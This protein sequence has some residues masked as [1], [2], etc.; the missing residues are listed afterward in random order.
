MT[1]SAETTLRGITWNHTRGFAPVVT[2][3]QVYCDTQEVDVTWE[4]R[5]LW[6]FGEG[7]LAELVQRYDLIVIDHPFAGTCAN[8]RLVVPLDT[9]LPADVLAE[10]AEHSVGPSFRS[11]TYADRQWALPLDAAAQVA[12][13]RE[14]L[15]AAACL[16]RPSTWDEALELAAETGKVAVPLSPVNAA[17][18]FFSLCTGFGEEPFAMP[19]CIVPRVVAEQVLEL[20]QRLV[21]VIPPQCLSMNPI[22]VLNWASS[23]DDVIYVPLTFGYV[24]YSHA[25]YRPSRL[26]FHNP[27]GRDIG[28]TLGGAGIAI[29]AQSRHPYAAAELAAW[30]TSSE[31]QRTSFALSGGQPAHAA[32]WDDPLLDVV[33]DGF[34]RHTRASLDGAYVRPTH[35]W[36]PGVQHRVAVTVSDFLRGS[37]GVRDTLDDLTARPIVATR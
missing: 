5:S 37:R 31:C 7:P 20:L 33:A 32:A 2:A 3:S 22:A 29:S 13:C 27:P 25:G 23:T 8:D 15:M 24:N 19:Q 28:S 6:H 35:D 34:F 9:V 21:A 12:A 18:A 36:F 4:R 30:L 17:C 1:E 26:T 14:D 16:S 11:Y 10:R